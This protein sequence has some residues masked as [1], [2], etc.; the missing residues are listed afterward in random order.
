MTTVNFFYCTLYNLFVDGYFM[1]L[2]SFEI[3]A[4]NVRM[5]NGQSVEQHTDGSGLAET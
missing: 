2:K 3:S 1:T 4:V 5:I